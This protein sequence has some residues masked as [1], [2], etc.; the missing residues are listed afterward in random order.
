V[1]VLRT[2][3]IGAEE[4][5]R[6]SRSELHMGVE[7][8]VVLYAKDAAE[9]E[10]AIGK[11]MARIAELDKRLSDYEADSELSKLSE[12]SVVTKD[13]SGPYSAVK[14]SDDLWTV[15]AESQ[16]ISRESEGAFDVS[17]GALTK[18][19]RRARRWKELPEA[20]A[21]AAAKAS[22]GYRF[23]QLDSAQHTARLMHPNMRLDLGGIAKGYAADEG[24][25][26]AIA[27]GVSRVLV[28]A[29]GDIVAGEA[30]PGERG[31]R[32]GIAPLNPDEPPQRF[33]EISHCGIS[34]SGD[35]R[36]HLV[37]NGRRY[38]HIID[39]RS[40]E[41][42]AGR[43]SVTVIAPRGIVADALATAASV[44]GPEK[45]LSACERFPGAELLMVY[46]SE[47]GEQRTV[48]SAGFKRYDGEGN[49]EV[50]QNAK[51]SPRGKGN[52]R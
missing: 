39:P 3:A 43:S 41:C 37:I 5:Q 27:A 23:L 10:A 38:S 29:S 11:A 25:K 50:I 42:V 18:L 48:E 2:A 47:S 9:A 24:V 17:I 7:F 40:G 35:A 20:E 34:T 21:L 33:V 51:P 16:A 26:A 30:P 13:K 28:R 45:A 19:W 1:L 46:E 4:L 31:W 52:D 22:V 49:A 36:Q 15:L 8:E 6:F 44:L 12:T 32:V 14:V